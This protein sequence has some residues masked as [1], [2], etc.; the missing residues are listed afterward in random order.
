M[1]VPTLTKGGAA[2]YQVCMDVPTEAMAGASVFVEETL[3]FN[4]S[5]AYWGVQ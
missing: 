3:S 4:D 1:D 2:D 5:R